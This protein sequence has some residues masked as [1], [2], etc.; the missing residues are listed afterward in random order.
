MMLLTVGSD[1]LSGQAQTDNKGHSISF[2]ADIGFVESGVYTAFGLGTK[3]GLTWA[4]RTGKPGA[5]WRPPVDWDPQSAAW[6]FDGALTVGA[7]GTRSGTFLVAADLKEGEGQC[8]PKFVRVSDTEMTVLG[9]A[10]S[11][12]ILWLVTLEHGEPRVHWYYLPSFRGLYE[13]T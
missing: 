9:V 11:D 10:L 12:D 4:G 8:S 3:D 6:A 2:G 13:K 7:F 5:V 1:A